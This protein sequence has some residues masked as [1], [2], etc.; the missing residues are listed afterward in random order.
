MF[1][2]I[3][4]VFVTVAADAVYTYHVS[5]SWRVVDDTR[6]LTY[7]CLD[8]WL[9][10]SWSG[11]YDIIRQLTDIFRRERTRSSVGWLYSAVHGLYCLDL[12]LWFS[13]NGTASSCH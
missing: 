2:V 6:Q 5:V 10:R 1:V 7:L 4:G 11:L 8:R 12:L 13:A 9:P 3:I